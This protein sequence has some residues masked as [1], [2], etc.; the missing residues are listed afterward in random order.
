MTDRP[1]WA[2]LTVVEAAPGLKLPYAHVQAGS[3]VV[4]V[5]WGI[6]RWHALGRAARW[7]RDH[8]GLQPRVA[9]WATRRA[10]TDGA[11]PHRNRPDSD[12]S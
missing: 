8:S 5:S 3:T 12:R 7:A 4:H 1:H 2:Q 10:A 6:S 9:R 11:V